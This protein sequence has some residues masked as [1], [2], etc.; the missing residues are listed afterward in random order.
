MVSPLLSLIEDQVAGLR[1]RGIEASMMTSSSTK[2]EVLMVYTVRE[3][4]EGGGR[5]ITSILV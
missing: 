4:E 3:R 5:S 1:R 2:E